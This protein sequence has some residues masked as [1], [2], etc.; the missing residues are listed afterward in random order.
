MPNAIIHTHTYNCHLCGWVKEGDKRTL[1]HA[2]NLHV[3]LVHGIKPLSLELN[4]KANL[5]WSQFKNQTAIPPVERVMR[6]LLK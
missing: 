3:R 6:P 1:R 2:V 5:S 4:H